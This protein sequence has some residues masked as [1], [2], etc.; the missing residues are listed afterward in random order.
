MEKNPYRK[1]IFFFLTKHS[2][3]MAQPKRFKPKNMED[4]VELKPGIYA[5]KDRTKQVV[6]NPH[7]KKKKEAELAKS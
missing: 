6:R 4:F 3:N 5:R 1:D 7:K 2:I